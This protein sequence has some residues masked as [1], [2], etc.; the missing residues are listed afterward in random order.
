[1]IDTAKGLSSEFTTGFTG[2]ALSLVPGTP[3]FDLGRTLDTLQATAGFDT[4]QEMRNNSPTGGAL[5]SVTEREL[6]LLQATWS[7][8]SQA[9]S[10]D[11]FEANLDRFKNQVERS[12]NRVNQA[13]ER[14]YG[15][16]FFTDDSQ[17]PPVPSA[18]ADQIPESVWRLM[19]PQERQE[20][21]RAN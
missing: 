20:F 17:T 16:P 6:A 10:K 15:E 9:Q 12:W 14:D 11:Q 18:Y 21:M 5:G 4:L 13:Y 3:A 2:G 1:M 7:S 19:T 8:V